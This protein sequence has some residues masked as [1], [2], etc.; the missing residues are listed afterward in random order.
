MHCSMRPVEWLGDQ[1]PQCLLVIRWREE[2][3]LALGWA[4]VSLK[5]SGWQYL[6]RLYTSPYRQ[7]W[8]VD[9]L[10][11]WSVGI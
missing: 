11:C 10:W 4:S 3:H 1:Q 8:S 5:F 6:A 2:A 7:T 9:L